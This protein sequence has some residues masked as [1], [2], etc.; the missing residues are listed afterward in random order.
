MVQLRN[1]LKAIFELD[2]LNA[3]K[4]GNLCDQTSVTDLQLLKTE[5]L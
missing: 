2:R 3:K 4:A 5:M 1:A